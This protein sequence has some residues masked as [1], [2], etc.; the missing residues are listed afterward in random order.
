MGVPDLTSAVKE[1]CPFMKMYVFSRPHIYLVDILVYIWTDKKEEKIFSR[2]SEL[3]V[4]YL[5]N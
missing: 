1:I 3:S 4:D 2:F 5:R